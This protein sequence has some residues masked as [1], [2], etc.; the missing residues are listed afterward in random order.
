MR[1]KLQEYPIRQYFLPFCTIFMVLIGVCQRWYWTVNGRMPFNSD[2]AV[3]GLMARHIL[4]GERPVFFYGQAY[5]GS[6]DAWLNAIAFQL[7]GESI[8]TMRGLQIFLWLGLLVSIFILAEKIQKSNRAGWWTVFLLSLPPVNV[9]LYTTVSLGGYNE[10]LILGIW[11]LNLAVEVHQ[12]RAQRDGLL[13]YIPIFILGLLGGFGLW[14]FGFS[15]LFSIPATLFTLAVIW[16]FHQ[17]TSSKVILSGLLLLG[18]MIGAY[19]WIAYAVNHGLGGLVRELGGSAVAVETAGVL[20]TTGL[21]LV[22]FILLGVPA[23]L[24]FRPPWTT[25]WLLLPL[26][27]VVLFLWF[28][29]LVRAFKYAEKKV[30]LFL[31]AAPVGLLFLVFILSSFGI[32]PSGRY[33]LPISILLPI[34][35]GSVLAQL[36]Q[37]KPGF[38]W[39]IA[40][41]LILY[42]G[43]GSIQAEKMSPAGLTT[44]FAPHTEIEHGQL[45]AVMQFLDE[46]DE[47]TGFTTY[48]I[49]YPMAFLSN[50]EL[51]FIPRLP[52]HQD[53]RYTARDDRYPPYTD[54]VGTSDRIA[55]VTHQFPALDSQIRALLQKESLIWQEHTIAGYTIFYDLSGTLPITSL[56]E[57]YQNAQ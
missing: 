39:A 53:F 43:G 4:A 18:S 36:E 34:I 48:W 14:A 2:E 47:T 31:L 56:E 22:G 17:V 23:A 28:W 32:D 35:G 54:R 11:S 25:Q 55:L 37:T 46:H 10:A 42:Q 21:H 33:F 26:I 41:L 51:I 16:K 52:Y 44:Q 38:A 30:Y 1:A 9:V 3:V 24:G 49:S 40:G 45:E 8:S 15:L 13:G 29:L 50:E 57:I 20:M 5:M 19:P 6:L 7:F 12:R 27:P